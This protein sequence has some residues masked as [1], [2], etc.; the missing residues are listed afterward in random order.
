MY[1]ILLIFLLSLLNVNCYEI[2]FLLF[3]NHEL[4]KASFIEEQEIYKNLRK[5]SQH[6]D[7]QKHNFHRELVCREDSEPVQNS[8]SHDSKS[9]KIKVMERFRNSLHPDS[10]PFPNTNENYITSKLENNFTFS[11][12][13]VYQTVG[14]TSILKAALKGVIMLQETYVPNIENFASGN[15]SLKSVELSS[16]RRIDSL[17]HLDLAMLSKIAFNELN[18]FDSA[19]KLLKVAIDM[20]YNIR[21]SVTANYGNIVD[22]LLSSMRSKYS[23]Y[24]NEMALK[25]DNPVGPD[26]KVYPYPVDEGKLVRIKGNI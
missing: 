11:Y 13:D 5:I 7:T 10:Y 8:V 3:E 25:V 17:N 6:L 26:W 14:K 9:F 16:S 4:T 19:I 24:H 18:W 1:R 2:D 22:D 20:F 12:E 21:D 23:L 15:L